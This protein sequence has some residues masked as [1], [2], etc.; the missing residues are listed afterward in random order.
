MYARNGTCRV[1]VPRVPAARRFRREFLRQYLRSGPSRIVSRERQFGMRARGSYA[2]EGAAA[3][4][5][6][7]SIAES[8]W[9]PW[10]TLPADTR[11]SWKRGLDRRHFETGL[12]GPEPHPRSRGRALALARCEIDRRAANFADAATSMRRHVL[13]I[14]SIYSSR[15][16]FLSQARYRDDNGQGKR[17]IA[18]RTIPSAPCSLGEPKTVSGGCF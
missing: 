17:C 3:A 6:P 14:I 2:L 18:G 4:T 8:S 11:V 7:L 5:P 12:R 10:R 13:Q 1:D 15:K 9:A 16:R